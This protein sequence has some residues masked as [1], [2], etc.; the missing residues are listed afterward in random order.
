VADGSAARARGAAARTAAEVLA[1]RI[2]T[3]IALGEF[4]QGQRLPAE[5][6]LAEILGVGRGTVRDALARVASLDLIDV[7]RGRTGGAYVRHAW[8]SDTA[9]AVREI[10]GKEWAALERT[11]DLRHLIEAMIARAAAERRSA[12]DVR[13]I[14]SAL[15]AYERA[16]DLADAQAADVRLH[17]AVAGATHNEALVELHERLLGEVSLGFAVEPFTRSIYDRALPE[18][19]AL[20]DAIASRDE[21]AA[22]DVGK[23]HFTITADELRATLDRARTP[24]ADIP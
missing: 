24:P 4:V 2:V 5:R 14:R 18:H 8:G 17:H 16:A 13:E 19:Q 6:E 12:T 3:A 7:R 10:L 15:R 9:T 20:A 1:D 22:W 21:Q 23:A 11:L